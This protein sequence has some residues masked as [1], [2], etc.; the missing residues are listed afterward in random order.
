MLVLVHLSLSGTKCD[1][2]SPAT[3]KIRRAHRLEAI[4]SQKTTFTA[5]FSEDVLNAV[6]LAWPGREFGESRC[7][8]EPLL[9]NGIIVDKR[10]HTRYDDENNP[11]ILILVII[12][13]MAIF[14]V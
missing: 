9:T 6:M 5:K 12:M 7:L 3:V 1:H 11:R 2:H 14:C 10:L 13:K 8:C 4:F